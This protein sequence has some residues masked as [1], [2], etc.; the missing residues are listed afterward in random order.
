[1]VSPARGSGRG[2]LSCEIHARATLNNLPPQ[3]IA[4]DARP[5]DASRAAA[6]RLSRGKKAALAVGAVL[7]TLAGCEIALRLFWENPYRHELPDYVVKLRLQHP[8]VDRAFDRSRLDPDEPQVRFRTNA[9]C[10]IEP[11]AQYETPDAT[12]AFLGGSTTECSAVTEQT[13]FPSR[14]STLLAEHGLRVS[15]LNSG[16]SGNTIHDSI[17]V[18]LNH[19]VSDRPDIV[20]VMHAANDIGV[21]TADGDYRSRSG[22]AVTPGNLFTWT[23]Q[24]ASQRVSLAALARNGL[25][26]PSFRARIGEAPALPATTP[27]RQ[28]PIEEYR[29]R[30]LALVHVCRDFGIEP[31]L[32]TQPLASRTNE[33]TP[34]WADAAAQDRFNGEVREVGRREGAS[35]IDLVEHLNR[36]APRWQEANELFYDGIHVNDRGSQEYAR[37]IAE[38][39]LPLLRKIMSRRGQGN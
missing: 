2:R 31:V 11:S 18:L 17:N 6:R 14:V 22:E 37:H 23:M 26:A 13:R 38:Q 8:N 19:V 35:V 9:R 1:V 12:V 34:A 4:K 32:M 16:R 39:L 21:L 7:V 24:M 5:T 20:V 3:P 36:S 30:L 25:F 27:D 33:L 15:T 10:Y 28:P 29:R